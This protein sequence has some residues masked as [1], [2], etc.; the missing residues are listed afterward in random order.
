MFE[1]ELSS[2]FQGCSMF[3]LDLFGLLRGHIIAQ[4]RFVT[5]KCVPPRWCKW[6]YNAF[7]CRQHWSNIFHYQFKIQRTTGTGIPRIRYQQWGETGPSVGCWIC[8]VEQP[9]VAFRRREGAVTLSCLH[10]MRSHQPR[11]DFSN[12]TW[13]ND[14]FVPVAR[15]VRTSCLE[16]CILLGKYVFSALDC[17]DF[18]Q[19]TRCF[20]VRPLPHA[21]PI[22]ATNG[23]KKWDQNNETYWIKTEHIR[24]SSH[25]SIYRV[26]FFW[27]SFCCLFCRGRV[28][29]LKK[30]RSVIS[31]RE[32]NSKAAW[33]QSLGPLV[34]VQATTVCRSEEENWMARF[35][36]VKHWKNVCANWKTIHP[37]PH[38]RSCIA[39]DGCAAQIDPNPRTII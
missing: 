34:K 31:D 24:R 22:P 16:I 21:W 19:A 13:K 4:N 38:G 17:L 1:Q 30:P 37:R 23:K 25:K 36:H 11:G 29:A 10:G 8:V 32:Y 12:K 26:V 9:D 28:D 2:E 6:V 15:K 5:L 39:R 18:L 14:P 27:S 20:R 7:D 33:Y 3:S 35:D